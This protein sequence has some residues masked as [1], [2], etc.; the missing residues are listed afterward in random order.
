MIGNWGRWGGREGLGG[1]GGG[2]GASMNSPETRTEN[3]KQYRRSREEKVQVFSQHQSG[4]GGRVS[5]GGGEGVLSN[6]HKAD[7]E[8][9]KGR[10]VGGGIHQL[11]K[12]RT[13][14]SN[15]T[16]RGSRRYKFSQ[17]QRG[18][19]WGQFEGREVG[20]GGGRQISTGQMGRGSGVVGRG[21]QISTD[22]SP[23][24]KGKQQ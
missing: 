19:W 16:G 15:K 18:V 14:S 24:I 7:G 9:E 8:G 21:G 3:L 13:K 5:G 1:P 17:Y 4:G 6:L 23:A 12:K 10:G 11:S 20:G 22:S 2:G